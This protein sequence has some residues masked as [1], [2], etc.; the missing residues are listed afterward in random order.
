MRIKRFIPA[1]LLGGVAGVL[2]SVF[3][4]SPVAAI[5][6]SDYFSY[7]Y[8][9]AF[10]KTSITGSEAF[11]VTVIGNANCVHDLPMTVSAANIVSTVIGRNQQTGAEVVLNPNYSLR[12]DNSFPNHTGQTA[13]VT[14]QVPLSFPGG[15]VP[16]TYDVIGTLTDA[17][18]TILGISFNVKAYLPSTQAM[19]VVNYSAPSTGG[20]GGGG[21]FIPTTTATT[22]TTTTT[23]STTPTVVSTST[24][25]QASTTPI[26]LTTVASV[27]ISTTTTKTVQPAV[28]SAASFAVSSLQLTPATVKNGKTVKISVLLSNTGDLAGMYKVVMQ[29]DGQ[30]A[31]SQE[32]DLAGKSSQ[33]VTFTHLASIE[34]PHIVSIGGLDK[35]LTVEPASTGGSIGWWIFAALAG[36]GIGILCGGA[37]LYALRYKKY[38]P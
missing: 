3:V 29:I 36:L 27:L 19:G 34:G 16:G 4:V 18:V 31:N 37:L 5:S 26:V 11:M 30:Y 38:R 15:S 32:I 20:G 12:Y 2:L 13:S 28:Q 22:T 35:S 24:T 23:S 25:S 8:N 1:A 14:V 7:S 17:D 33:T 21:V 9:F 6:V 10:S